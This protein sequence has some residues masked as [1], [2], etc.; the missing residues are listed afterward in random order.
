MRAVVM[1]FGYFLKVSDAKRV[2]MKCMSDFIAMEVELTGTKSL[3]WKL[4]DT[5]PYRVGDD[6]RCP[7][8]YNYLHHKGTCYSIVWPQDT[9][10]G[11]AVSW[12]EAKRECES[13]NSSLVSIKNQE[14]ADVVKV[15]WSAP[16][17]WMLIRSVATL[18][19]RKKRYRPH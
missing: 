17:L 16:G 3:I 12:N 6:P 4:S 1:M 5:D 18:Q 8:L 2:K 10:L 15:G 11:K 7:W 13:R 9:W 19:Y 14:E